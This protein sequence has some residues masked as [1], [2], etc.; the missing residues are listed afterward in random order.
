MLLI[1][2]F[3]ALLTLLLSLLVLFR[4]NLRSSKQ[5]AD[6]NEGTLSR[7]KATFLLLDLFSLTPQ[8]LSLPCASIAKREHNHDA[9]CCVLQ[10]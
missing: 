5:K 9:M 6:A 4:P 10:R 2:T 8:P 3:L 7:S 1:G